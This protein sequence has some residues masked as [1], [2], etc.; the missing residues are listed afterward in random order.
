[1]KEKILLQNLLDEVSKQTMDWI[2]K[3]AIIADLQE[4]TPL[5]EHSL[6]SV[7]PGNDR[8]FLVKLGCELMGKSVGFALPGMAALE[9][10]NINLLVTDDF[11]DKRT[12][13][14]MG[15]KTIREKWGD[16]ACISLGF[17]LKSLSSEILIA[18]CN[19]KSP[20]KLKD[21]LETLEWATKRQYYSQFL[22]EKLIKMPLS[23]ITLEMYFNLIE[24]ATSSGTAGALEMGCIMGCGSDKDRELFRSFGVELGNLLQIR[25]DLIDYIY[26]EELIKKGPFNDL[27][28]KKRRLPILIS[29]WLGTPQEKRK[30]DE[31]FRK[32]EISLVDVFSI[33]E[34]ITLPKVERK[35]KSIVRDTRLKA[36]KKLNLLPQEEPAKSVLIDI[37][38]LFSD[39]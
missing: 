26:N 4:L 25:D 1:M 15:V 34:I 20:W 36:I 17:I 22:E 6:H 5:I 2:Y 10:L 37:V 23:D 29:Y 11:F 16:E 7:V 35:I 18:S 30:I 33:I 12:S 14:R 8:A 39:L 28:A 27:L 9:F 3:N 31:I 24:N 19:D 32:D 21:A 38:T 13:M